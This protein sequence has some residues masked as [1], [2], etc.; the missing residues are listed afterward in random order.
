MQ[1]VADGVVGHEADGVLVADEP[2]FLY[3]GDDL[4]VAEEDGG[5]VVV[6]AAEGSVNPEH[7]HRGHPS[8]AA[9]WR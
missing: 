3:R 7:I 5:S 8:L 1:H 9:S 4:G 6:G 2:F